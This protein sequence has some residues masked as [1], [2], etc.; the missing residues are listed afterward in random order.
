M[1]FDCVASGPGVVSAK[2]AEYTLARLHPDLAAE[3]VCRFVDRFLSERICERGEDLGKRY[4]DECLLPVFV[5]AGYIVKDDDIDIH[6]AGSKF[7]PRP[8]SAERLFDGGDDLLFQTR[9][10]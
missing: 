5:I 4:D 1:G 6:G 3:A 2:L 9:G 10:G 7:I 8:Y